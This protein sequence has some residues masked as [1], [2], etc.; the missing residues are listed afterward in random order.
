MSNDVGTVVIGAG[1]VGLAAGRALAARGHEVLVLEQADVAGSEVS[2]RNSEVIHAGLYYPPGSFKAR[3][4]VEGKKA[5]YRF[6]RENGVMANRCGKLVVATRESEIPKLEAL[7]A[8]ARANGVDDLSLLSGAE[9]H[10]LEPELR[11]VAALLSPST[12]V[13]DSHAYMQALEGYIGGLGGQVVFRTRVT[14]ATARPAGGFALEVESEGAGGQLTCGR[15]VNAAGLGASA[16]GALLHRT[17]GYRPPRTYPAK[18]HYFQVAGSV[19]FRHLIY[20]MP[21]EAWLG[22]HL[23]F[24]CGGQAKLGPDLEWVE[25]V[26]YAFD[27]PGGTRLA[28]FRREA[29]RYWPGLPEDALSPDYTGIRPKIY[30]EGEPPADFTIHGPETHGLDGFVGLYGIESPGLTSSLA[31]G[32]H[33]ADLLSDSGDA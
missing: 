3:F 14:G 1:V 13:V 24:D 5:L 11:C 12:G 22:L 4:C 10:A 26:D 20:P 19:P 18:G 28:L 31:I 23:T 16:I 8:N 21:D 33:V 30:L 7:A 29:R 9:A 2:S 32:T 27:D 6:C 25:T 17:G 15:L